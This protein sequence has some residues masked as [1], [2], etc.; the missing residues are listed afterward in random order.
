VVRTP[1]LKISSIDT[2]ADDMQLEISADG[3]QVMKHF[4]DSRSS[5][6]SG[7]ENIETYWC[8]KRNSTVFS[9]D[10]GKDFDP[11]LTSCDR[12]TIVRKKGF[13]ESNVAKG[14]RRDPGNSE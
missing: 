9:I 12:T 13:E 1:V 5:V 14:K 10:Y 11:A 6:T 2:L 3:Q 7:T 4:N 8:R